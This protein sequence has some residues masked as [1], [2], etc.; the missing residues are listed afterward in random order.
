MNETGYVYG[1]VLHDFSKFFTKL[2]KLGAFLKNEFIYGHHWCSMNASAIALSMMILFRMN[3]KWEFVLIAYLGTQCIYTYNHY[4]ELDIDDLDSSVRVGHIRKYGA[5]YPT[6]IKLYGIFFLVFLFLYGNLPSIL[7]GNFL[8][9]IGLVYTTNVKKASKNIIGFK[10]IYTSIS[11]GLLIIFT[12]I[13]C[14]YPLTLGVLLFFLFVILRTMII[15]IFYDI[16][17]INSDRKSGLTTLPMVFKDKNSLLN[18]LHV[19]NMISLLP[20]IFGVV[21]N[22]FPIYSLFLLILI[23][24]GFAFLQKAKNISSDI[25]F[26]SYIITDGEQN[27]WLVLLIIGILI[28]YV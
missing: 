26:L 1:I 8:L 13:Y 19:L 24:Y 15:T 7:F 21:I 6:F 18:F 23:L 27:I 9:F 5:W 14:S 3:I 12:T 28:P 22:I 2:N 20:I 10:S 25:N 16:K 4:K 11:W 17:D